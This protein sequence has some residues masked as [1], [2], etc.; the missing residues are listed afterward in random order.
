[1]PDGWRSTAKSGCRSGVGR[2]LEN[3]EKLEAE[4]ADTKGLEDARIIALSWQRCPH[5]KREASL[6]YYSDQSALQNRKPLLFS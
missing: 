1:M 5:G 2:G 6:I 3:S 4:K